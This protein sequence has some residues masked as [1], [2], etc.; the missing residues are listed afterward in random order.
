LHDDSAYLQRMSEVGFLANILM[1][2]CSFQSRRFRAAEA[3]DAVYSMCNLGLQNWPDHWLRAP[4]GSRASPQGTSL[5]P[6]LL[7][8]QNLVTA[9]KI[10]WSR[11]Y[12]QVCLHT[13]RRL[14]G[15]LPELICD[16]REIQDDLTELSRR[17]GSQLDA[18]TPWLERDNLD[19]IA[20]LDQPTW[21]VL[22][23]LLDEC[24][25]A[26]VLTRTSMGGAR[27]LRLSPRFEFFAVSSQVL[28]ARSFVESLPNLLV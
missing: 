20:I 18:G 4:R 14:A 24:P 27:S 7:L 28:W 17:L 5:P 16:D 26:P 9:F 22:L 1:A 8:R 2:G 12:Q 10:G 25:V 3:A 23:G 19:V 11:V 21:A 6:D 13:A 15:I